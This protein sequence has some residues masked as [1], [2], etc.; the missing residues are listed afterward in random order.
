MTAMA[1]VEDTR[2]EAERRRALQPLPLDA[3]AFMERAGW[4][5]R[6]DL[7]ELLLEAYRRGELAPGALRGVLVRVWSAAEFPERWV[8]RRVWVAWFRAAAFPRPAEPL[9]VYR[10]AIPRYARGMA[11]TTNPAR[12]GSRRVGHGR[13]GSP[14]M[15]RPGLLPPVR[16]A[17]PHRQSVRVS[18]VA[19]RWRACRA[20]CPVARRPRAAARIAGCQPRL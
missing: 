4:Y 5:G 18:P 14:P 20:A 6:N 8:P 1:D 9:T 17:P 13:S 10:G 16:A 19:L 3:A 11:W 7:P 12:A 15:G 2:A